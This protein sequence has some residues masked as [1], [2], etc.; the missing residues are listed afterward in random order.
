MK[1]LLITVFSMLCF[2]L[3]SSITSSADTLP[4]N[5]IDIERNDSTNFSTPLKSYYS[6]VENESDIKTYKIFLGQNAS[7]KLTLMTSDLSGTNP[8]KTYDVEITDEEGTLISAKNGMGRYPEY[9]PKTVSVV[10]TPGVSQLQFK[11]ET[12]GYYYVHVKPSNDGKTQYPY[13]VRILVGEPFYLNASKPYDVKLNSIYLTQSASSS[14]QSFDLSNTSA[15]PADAILTDFTVY[16]TETNRV[17]VSNL[18]GITRSLK[19]NS[20]L[21]WINT[22]YP[23]YSTNGVL[24][25]QPKNAQIKMRQPFTF[26]KS[27]PILGSGTYSLTNAYISMSYKHELK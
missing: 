13:N 12:A 22:S 27:A 19:P 10:Y 17:I 4:E 11:T 8:K 18:Y 7:E 9:D 5:V 26:K 25:D 23:F 20:Q 6:V 3:L 1:K 14:T 21:S 15:I 2:F 24:W 16:G